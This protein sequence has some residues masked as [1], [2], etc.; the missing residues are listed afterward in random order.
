MTAHVVK[1]V[2]LAV[3]VANDDDRVTRELE[4]EEAAWRRD[5][6]TRSGVQP[7]GAPDPLKLQLVFRRIGEERAGKP[8][9]GATLRE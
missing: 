7:A 6:G 8:V 4:R 5:L 2:Q 3:L 9:S 1:C